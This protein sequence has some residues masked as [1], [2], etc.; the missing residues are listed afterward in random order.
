MEDLEY[1]IHWACFQGHC[2]V[3]SCFILQICYKD[4]G[5]SVVLGLA[6]LAPW[7]YI[8]SLSSSYSPDQCLMKSGADCMFGQISDITLLSSPKKA[9]YWKLFQ[10]NPHH[11]LMKEIRAIDEL[12]NFL[13]VIMK[14]IRWL[15]NLQ[16]TLIHK[17][18]STDVP[19]AQGAGGIAMHRGNKKLARYQL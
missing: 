17:N 16:A 9:M 7:I 14:C 12:W 3:I 6:Y 8:T 13:Y 2:S 10:Y 11:H 19:Q 1:T 5:I 15:W 18:N 4:H